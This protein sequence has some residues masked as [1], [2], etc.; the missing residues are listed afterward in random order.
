MID[1][2]TPSR[3]HP[4][5]MASAGAALLALTALIAAAGPM[6]AQA[7]ELGDPELQVLPISTQL[8]V[9]DDDLIL[10][11]FDGASAPVIDPTAPIQLTLTG[12]DGVAREPVT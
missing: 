11:L 3:S 4:A 12:P 1:P 10:Q 5:R 6:A 8:W 2:R 7:P 9:G